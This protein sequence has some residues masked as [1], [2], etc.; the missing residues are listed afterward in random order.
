MENTP[1]R[2][3]SAGTF[4]DFLAGQGM[5]SACEAEA[6]K[7]IVAD[8]IRLATLTAPAGAGIED[9]LRRL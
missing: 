5:L 8:Q 4:D 6:I 2:R 3:S 7:E 1:S 9:S